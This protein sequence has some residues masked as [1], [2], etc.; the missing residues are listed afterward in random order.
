MIERYACRRA[1]AGALPGLT[2]ATP[3][4]AGETI[5]LT[6]AD[7]VAVEGDPLSEIAV[8]ESVSCVMKAGE[9][10]RDEPNAGD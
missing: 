1:L 3:V 6:A 9:V 2:S 7:L 4:W 10:F 8:L 5:Y